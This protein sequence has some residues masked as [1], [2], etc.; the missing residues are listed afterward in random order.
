MKALGKQE[1][2]KN[3]NNLRFAD[4]ISNF[5]DLYPKAKANFIR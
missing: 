1:R 5:T 3:W 2:W 4:F